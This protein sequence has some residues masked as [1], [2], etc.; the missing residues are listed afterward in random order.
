MSGAIIN[1]S[2]SIVNVSGQWV[3]AVGTN[4]TPVNQTASGTL[5]AVLVASGEV[6]LMYTQGNSDAVSVNRFGLVVSPYNLIYDQ[7]ANGW[8]RMSAAQSGTNAIQV[9][10]SGF[11][12]VVAKVSGEAVSISG[13]IIIGRFSGETFKQQ[14]PTTGR[15]RGIAKVTS[16]SG[17]DLL[18]SG[19]VK[20]MT[21]RMVQKASGGTND[22]SGYMLVGFDVAGERPFVGASGFEL[23]SGYGT[24]ILYPGDAYTLD[25]DNMNR[26]RV[27]SRMSG[28]MIS[29]GGNTY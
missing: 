5:R 27:V 7:A 20:T 9:A 17:G 23:D 19:D 24:I 28:E 18:A 8:R 2:G 26:M 29:Y 4:N 21:I 10:T 13:N 1:I 12:Y 25:I 22:A 14:I 11:P 16:N 6:D 3:V 15:A